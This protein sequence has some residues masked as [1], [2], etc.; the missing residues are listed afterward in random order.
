MFVQPF[1]GVSCLT[2]GARAI[3]TGVM[4][5]VRF[6][7]ISAVIHVSPQGLGTALTDVLDG[8]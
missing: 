2:L 8:F 5:N 7:A 4:K 6:A 3:V 1:F